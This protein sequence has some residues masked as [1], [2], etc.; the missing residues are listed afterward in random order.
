MSNKNSE[1]KVGWRVCVLNEI[2][3]PSPVTRLNFYDSAK[4]HWDLQKSAG[5]RLHWQRKPASARIGPARDRP[6]Y[7]QDR[8]MGPTGAADL[9]NAT[10][11]LIGGVL[12]LPLNLSWDIAFFSNRAIEKSY[13]RRLPLSRM[14]ELV[15]TV[16]LGAN[17]RRTA[18]IKAHWV[19]AH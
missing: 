1:K 4:S 13:G 8:S 17:L 10:T 5:R 3:P 14:C 18:E 19:F 12:T 7:W 2:P 15:I 16:K 11:H 9:P 6:D